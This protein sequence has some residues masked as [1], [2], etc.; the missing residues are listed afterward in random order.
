M[1]GI[2]GVALLAFTAVLCR[3][4]R[5][6]SQDSLV[7]CGLAVAMGLM[8]LASG[9]ANWKVQL[10]QCTLQAVVGFCCYAQLRRESILRARR[11]ALHL[12]RAPRSNMKTCA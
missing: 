4:Y 5:P 1:I 10:I 6:R 2:T 9:P 12:H 8:A 3:K 7:L 11:R